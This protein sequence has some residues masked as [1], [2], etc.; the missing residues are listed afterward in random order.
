MTNLRAAELAQ[1]L[2]TACQPDGVAP[3]GPSAHLHTPDFS[4]A[5]SDVRFVE[6]WLSGKAPESP[7]W[8]RHAHGSHAH[9]CGADLALT[10]DTL[11]H[12]NIGT[13][14]RYLHARPNDY[15]GLHLSS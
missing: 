1:L 15:S 2:S 13:T 14:S 6:L 9:A 10:Q 8:L 5:Q 11:R 3:A 12:S 7:H 4:G